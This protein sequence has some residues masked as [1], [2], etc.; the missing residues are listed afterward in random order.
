MTPLESGILTAIESAQLF[1]I[2][3]SVLGKRV[4]KYW[5][6]YL[7]FGVMHALIDVSKIVLPDEVSTILFFVAFI[8]LIYVV[9][10]KRLLPSIA[11]GVYSFFILFVMQA[12]ITGLFSVTIGV[13]HT[14]QYGIIIMPMTLVIAILFYLCAP[15]RIVGKTLEEKKEF[16]IWITILSIAFLYLMFTLRFMAN[17]L[18]YLEDVGV[19]V[20]SIAVV[21]AIAYSVKF[22][23]EA[24]RKREALNYYEELEASISER[25]LEPKSIEK[26]LNL[27]YSL[28]IIDDYDKSK[29]HARKYLY[30]F[31]GDEDLIE[32][33]RISLAMYLYVKINQLKDAGITCHLKV[34][35]Y[36]ISHKIK[37]Y[38]LLQAVDIIVDN[39]VEALEDGDNEIHINVT[40]EE[41]RRDISPLVEV[42]NKHKEIGHEEHRQFYKR[43]FST[44]EN[45]KGLGLYKL[46]NLAKDNNLR[47]LF[48][49]REI[50][51]ENYV[52]FGIWLVK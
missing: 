43:G 44:K 11:F 8:A 31:N 6:E 34:D 27:I 29:Y 35:N 17:G 15:F 2:V 21:T 14:F 48:E 12:M 4:T 33:R 47:I 1:L 39:A 50:E 25:D 30:N 46:S 19:F 13:E 49:N 22:V 24:S 23:I 20:L 26:N 16:L 10:D 7:I 45:Q 41:D 3:T 51:G 40:Q 32:I 28:S 52:C 5:K 18:G 38:D 37:D 9:F 36:F 42:L